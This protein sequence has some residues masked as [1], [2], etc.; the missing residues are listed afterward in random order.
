MKINFIICR[1]IPYSSNSEAIH[2]FQSAMLLPALIV[3]RI[4]ILSNKNSS[5]SEK[6]LSRESSP[7]KHH[8]SREII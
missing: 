4:E 5:H 6:S 7:P 2:L 8:N 1:T 3:T